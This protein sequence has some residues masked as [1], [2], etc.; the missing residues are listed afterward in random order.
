DWKFIRWI[1]PATDSKILTDDILPTGAAFARNAEGE[2]GILFTGD[3]GLKYF[4]EKNPAILLS[5]F[6]VSNGK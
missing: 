3:W 4:Q 2:V 6:P 1:D 5:E